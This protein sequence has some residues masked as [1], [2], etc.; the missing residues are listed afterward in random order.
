[1]TAALRAEWTKLRSVRS[2]PWS[3]VALLAVSVLFSAVIGS[4]TN[5]EGPGNEDVVALSLAGLFFGQLAAAALGVLAIGAEYGTGTI[6]ATFAA[7][8]RRGQV[9]L[10]KVALVGLLALAVGAAASVGSFFVGTEL[11]HGQGF[12][13][14]NGYLPVS[15]LDADTLE[16]VGSSSLYLALL[17]LLGLGITTAV[18]HSAAATGI[19]LGVLLVPL[20]AA[21]LLPERIGDVVEKVTPMIGLA[22]QDEH[23][24][25]ALWG[26]M[27]ITAAWAV[28]S[29]VVALVLVARRDT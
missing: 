25:I 29:L 17:A 21:V 3:L 1:V 20:I 15:I 23:G 6:R 19:L 7:N 28:G 11:L 9:L 26:G 4:T 27:A 18:R 14:A 12:N 22:A 24:P 5:T 2:T 13:E 8:P 16:A 10:A